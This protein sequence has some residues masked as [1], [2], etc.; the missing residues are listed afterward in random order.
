MPHYTFLIWNI[1]S[2]LIYYCICMLTTCE[3]FLLFCLYCNQVALPNQNE[4]NRYYQSEM[5]Y[6][7]Y[8]SNI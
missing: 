3:H 2:L 8:I 7:L 5:F 6:G 1:M 4:T